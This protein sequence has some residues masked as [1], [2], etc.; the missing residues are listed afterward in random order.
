MAAHDRGVH[1]TAPSLLAVLCCAVLQCYFIREQLLLHRFLMLKMFLSAAC[2]SVLVFTFLPLLS[3]TGAERIAH[4]RT[5]MTRTLAEQ[6]G[7]PALVMGGGLLGVGMAV[8]GSCPGTV[9]AQVGSGSHVARF[10]LAGGILAAAI[11]PLLELLPAFSQA[12][13][14]GRAKFQTQTLPDLL[15]VTR[16]DS[17]RVSLVVAVC[18]AS[19]VGALEYFFPWRVELDAL[20][21]LQSHQGISAAW[22][23]LPAAVPPWVAGVMVGSLQIPLILLVDKQ[24]GS[25]SSYVTLVANLVH[26][27]SPRACAK[28]PS[29]NSK[30]DG[31][32]QVWLM[33][34]VWLGAFVLTSAN[35]APIVSDYLVS[36]LQ[37]ILGGFFLVTGSRIASGCTSGHG[38]SGMGYLALNSFIAVAAMFGMGIVTAR[39]LFK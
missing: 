37:A 28:V 27:V 12:L 21:P 31:W 15:G 29:Y 25:S 35:E 24:L 22:A 26:A 10:V 2:T 18:F 9:F 30:R 7:V 3:R 17:W 33:C 14:R 6:R 1:H 16:T 39:I 38:I 11:Y 32:W 8:S 20:L 36:P 4:R 5:T 23:I 19:L 34:G 13:K